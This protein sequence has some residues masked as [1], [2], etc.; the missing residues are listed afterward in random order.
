[1][2]WQAGVTKK[3]CERKF[4]QGATRCPEISFGHLGASHHLDLIMVGR[5]ERCVRW[6]VKV[7]K[8]EDISTIVIAKTRTV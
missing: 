8:A 3:H 2:V 4:I 6:T 5:G 1:M 7:I